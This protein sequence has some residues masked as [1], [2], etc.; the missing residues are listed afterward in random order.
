MRILK[1]IPTAFGKF[2]AT[3][4]LDLDPGLNLIAGGNEAG[5]STLQAFILGML[6]GFKKEGLS[7]VKRTD[8]FEKYRPWHGR[9]YAG[10]MVYEHDGRRYRIERSFDPDSTAIFDDVTGEDITATFSQDSRKEY[11]FAQRHLGLSA[12]EFRNTVWI[13]QLGSKQEEG[14]GKEIQGKILNL[15]RGGAEDLSVAETLSI[16]ESERKKIGTSRTTEAV[17][18]KIARRISELE[19]ERK[20][21]EARES[22]V[23]DLLK[24]ASILAEKKAEKERAVD[25]AVR[26][27]RELRYVL[28]RKRLDEVSK[29]SAE[30][31]ELR[32]RERNLRWA[33]GTD[34]KA[35]ETLAVL[36][37]RLAEAQKNKVSLESSLAKLE[38]ERSQLLAQL[39]SLKAV[40][41]LGVTEADLASAYTTYL[42]AKAS[43]SQAERKLLARKQDES[44]LREEAR[45]R[46]IDPTL[47]I[48][49]DTV[50][51]AEKMQADL[52]LIEE[53]ERVASSELERARLEVA[54]T[55]PFAAALW[56]Y[57]FGVVAAALAVAGTFLTQPWAWVAFAAAVISFGLGV[58][59]HLVAVRGRASQMASIREKEQYVANLRQEVSRVR[60]SLNAFLSSFGVSSMGELRRKWHDLS[61]Y[62]ERLKAAADGVGEAL[63]ELEE[64]SN[65]LA[66]AENELVRVLRV[67]G[68]LLPNEPINEQAVATLRKQLAELNATENALRTVDAQT[69][70]RLEK[71]SEIAEEIS[72]LSGERTSILI[73][74][75]VTS[76]E[77][78]DTKIQAS[79]SYRETLKEI[80]VR[81]KNLASLLAGR[82]PEDLR[83]ELSLILEQLSAPPAL[84][85]FDSVTDRDLEQAREELGELERELSAIK[86]RLAR[87]E[88]LVEVKNREGRPLSEVVE[89]LSELQAR[90]KSLQE[91]AEALLVAYE[92]VER[93]SA[94]IHRE[95]APDL[96]KRAGEVLAGITGGRYSEVKLTPELEINVVVPE[97]Q[98]AV[99]VSQLSGGAI[100]QAYFAL[101]VALAEIL[102][103]H[104]D[105][106]LFLDDSFVQYDDE[107]L[108]GALEII[109]SLSASH[110]V[111][112]FTCHTR[113]QAVLK[114]LG[115]PH[116]AI[117]IMDIGW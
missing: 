101:R 29:V 40:K 65:A 25:A 23:R 72:R 75:G 95:F 38:E 81:E 37:A 39:D 1:L 97:T 83:Q 22:E 8:E 90:R 105:F 16:L 32:A 20:A 106:P 70:E 107:R 18:D 30:L 85:E 104:K 41:Q 92:V 96:S 33:A 28:I 62:R 5:K 103:G 13:G 58:V 74:Q 45:L 11:D 73:S 117:H 86:E 114:S 93:V 108:R 88:E 3:K 113:E 14:L 34:E 35:A 76:A 21:A 89:E 94:E 79:R 110:Q 71:L 98:R 36:G 80:E 68:C 87:L 100:D 43:R 26:K 78:L 66:E 60:D 84:S 19:R 50:D 53:R 51:R 12:R 82:T 6:Y 56:F 102:S 31:D 4:P 10:V 47:E 109:S 15:T 42:N 52:E 63:K 55:D 59:R 112:L 2:H 77:E 46:G 115:I 67:T 49:R 9:D 99:K 64:A 27:V 57:V 61:E 44:R 54:A 111:I 24:E 69:R 17:L 7:R 116:R 91:D 48:A